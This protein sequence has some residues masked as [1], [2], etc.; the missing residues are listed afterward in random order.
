MTCEEIRSRLAD[1]HER[2]LTAEEHRSIESHLK[3]CPMCRSEWTQ[4]AETARLLESMPESYPIGPRRKPRSSI[5]APALQAAALILFVAGAVF[6]IRPDSPVIPASQDEARKEI[7]KGVLSAAAMSKEDWL[8]LRDSEDPSDP[9]TINNQSLTYAAMSLPFVRGG[10][11]EFLSTRPS[12]LSSAIDAGELSLG[13]NAAV[14]SLAF[15]ENGDAV[16]QV[17]MAV[18]NVFRGSVGFT[19]RKIEGRWTPIEFRIQRP[20]A[21]VSRQKNGLWKT[22]VRLGFAGDAC[23]EPGMYECLYCVE[24]ARDRLTRVSMVMLKKGEAFPKCESAH[25]SWWQPR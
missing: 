24:A 17:A 11:F 23:L 12:E 22:T 7:E 15:Q 21:V 1:Y 3:E 9:K 25:K 5:L 6:L 18:P 16:G 8:K 14:T 10:D 13:H 19:A 20:A 4:I 2:A